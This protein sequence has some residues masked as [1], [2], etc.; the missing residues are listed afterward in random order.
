MGRITEA[1]KKI[2]DDR[3]SRIQKKPEI[4]YVI[5]RVQ[6]SSIDEHIVSFHDPSS[7][8]GE[9]YK[10]LRT[11]IQTVKATKGHKAFVMTSS[12]NKEGKTA[13]AINLAI[14]MA[15]DLNNKTILLIDADMRKGTMA[16]YLGLD[17]SPGLCEVLKGEVDIDS[18]LVNPNIDNLTVLASG[19]TP[20]NPS[21]LLNSKRMEQ[22]IASLKSRFDYIFIDAPPVMPLADAC[23]LGPMADGVIVIIRA[24]RTQRDMVKHVEH[25]LR[26]ARANIIGYV[27]T[28]VEYHIPQY[29]Y[30]Y[31]Q[32][33][34]GY[35]SYHKQNKVKEMEEIANEA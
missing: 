16:K 3:I 19:K 20:K 10:I 11:H 28:N 12:I 21:E 2:G 5:R 27:I 29:L 8:V 7:P 26:Q 4:Q 17:S 31:V 22:V 25:R 24:G 9:Q 18:V 34:G 23:I 13:T 1:L 6:N 15:G 30:R 32:E 14:S 33:Y 35:D